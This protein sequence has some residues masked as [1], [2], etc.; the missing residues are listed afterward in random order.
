MTVYTHAVIDIQMM[1]QQKIGTLHLFASSHLY[2]GQ[3]RVLTPLLPHLLC[4]PV[5]AHACICAVI[6]NFL[7]A[8]VY[9]NSLHSID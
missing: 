8:S 9:Y 3:A 4:G 7:Y 5:T 6:V 1:R 2:V